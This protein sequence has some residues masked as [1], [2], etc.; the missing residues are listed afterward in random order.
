[1][2]NKNIII[3]SEFITLA[4]LLKLSDV[5]ASGGQAKHFLA[6]NT[7]EIN[8][9]NDNRRGRKLHVGDKIVINNDLCLTLTNN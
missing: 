7:V 1:M 5:I 4:Q 9:V 6:N 2:L 3:R 8:G